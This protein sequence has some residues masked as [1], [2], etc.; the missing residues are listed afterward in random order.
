MNPRSQAPL[1]DTDSAQA[2][3]IA[4]GTPEDGVTLLIERGL[5]HVCVAGDPPGGALADCFREAFSSGALVASVPTLVDLSR[6]TGRV[7][8]ASLRQ[9]SNLVPWARD[10]GRSPRVAYLTN[11]PWFSAL[12]KIVAE[13]YPRSTHRRFDDAP[14]ALAWLRETPID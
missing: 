5:L 7:D 10:T 4:R 8:W 9:I 1:P 13:F 14:A 12:L 6:F 2:G 11:S 3:E